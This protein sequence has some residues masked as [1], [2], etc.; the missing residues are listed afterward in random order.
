MHKLRHWLANAQKT[1]VLYVCTSLNKNSIGRF[2]YDNAGDWLFI[3][4]KEGGICAISARIFS[5]KRSECF[6]S[7]VSGTVCKFSLFMTGL[8]KRN[9]ISPTC[10][11]YVVVKFRL[12]M[13]VKAWIR[14][15]LVTLFCVQNTKLCSVDGLC[16]Q[17]EASESLC[18]HVASMVEFCFS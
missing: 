2:G 4:H 14:K 6:V 11:H 13:M 1:C 3:V 10:R 5:L 8:C 18:F 12:S 9:F 16:G 7:L 17:R 15:W